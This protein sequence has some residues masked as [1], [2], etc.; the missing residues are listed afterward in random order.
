MLYLFVDQIRKFDGILQEY[1]GI[2][3]IYVVKYVEI[4]GLIFVEVSKDIWQVLKSFVGKEVVFYCFEED[5]GDEKGYEFFFWFIKCV[6]S[7]FRGFYSVYINLYFI[8]F[9]IGLQNW[10][11]QFWFS[12]IKEIINLYVMC[13]Y[14]F[15]CQYCKL[16]GLGIVFLKIDWIIECYQ[17]F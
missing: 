12:E 3:E 15:L 6:Y 14:E 7:L 5:V 1:D 8:F 13:L 11:M 16:D 17:L 2:C 10:F 4:F 9:F